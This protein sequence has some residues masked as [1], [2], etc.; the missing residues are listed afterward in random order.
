[1]GSVLNVLVLAIP[2]GKIAMQFVIRYLHYER[3]L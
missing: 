3:L 1:M 2:T